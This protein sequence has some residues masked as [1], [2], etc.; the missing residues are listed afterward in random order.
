MAVSSKT[1]TKM[2]Q[3]LFKKIFKTTPQPR[4]VAEEVHN[5]DPA[6]ISHAA[7]EV[8]A[9]LQEE[10]FEAFVVGGAVR[11]MLL[12][13][14]PKDFDV[15]TNAKPEEVKRC[16]RRA[17]IIG[18]RFRIVHVRI[19]RELIEVTTFRSA[20]SGG[21]VDTHGRILSDNAFGNQLE[22]ASR[23][24]FTVNALYY[25]PTANT[26]WDAH[27]GLAD[28]KKK[29][30][31]LIGKATLRFR[32]DPVRILRIL[33][34]SAKLGFN[35]DRGTIR[36]AHQLSHLLDMVPSARLADEFGKFLL[37]GYAERG[38]VTLASWGLLSRFLNGVMQ[39]KNESL[40]PMVINVL[41]DA[42]RR[43]AEEKSLSYSF[44]MAVMM[45]S[46]I[47]QLEQAFVEKRLP[48]KIALQD[49]IN[50]AV[51]L[52][53]KK[54]PL[55]KA[56][57]GE[58]RDFWYLQRTLIA[59]RLKQI[60]RLLEHRKLTAGID[61]LEIR[62]L[63]TPA[64]KSETTLKDWAFPTYNDYGDTVCAFW[65]KWW[66]ALANANADSQNSMIQDWQAHWRKQSQQAKRHGNGAQ[67]RRRKPYKRINTKST[68]KSTL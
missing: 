66:R 5:L 18:R 20:Q 13:K 50:E 33:R 15:A 19:G 47:A 62:A 1:F 52:Q 23:R 42:D 51:C 7:E 26:I 29:R 30:L 68:E 36:A 21:Q 56:V 63:N 65:A 59:P 9:I 39:E 31:R 22:D 49:A 27:D 44:L 25:D 46:K 4:V 67:H 55:T 24:D 64:Q 48:P 8:V 60:S 54:L 11:D 32:E 17:Y 28:L 2:I 38:L 40:L 16:F 14:T 61:F 57:I 45:W 12:G 6:Q 37:G 58:M 10:G 3:R 35:I 53:Q 41:H 43:H 34:F